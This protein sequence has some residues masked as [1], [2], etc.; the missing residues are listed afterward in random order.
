[1]SNNPNVLPIPPSELPNSSTDESVDDFV[2]E[3][4]N[5]CTDDFVDEVIHHTGCKLAN[6]IFLE[7]F[8]KKYSNNNITS[9]VASVGAPTQI[10]G[11]TLTESEAKY[12]D[13]Y[14]AYLKFLNINNTKYITD[15]NELISDGNYNYIEKNKIKMKKPE[16]HKKDYIDSIKLTIETLNNKLKNSNPINIMNDTINTS[17]LANK[18]HNYKKSK[19]T[20]D[21]NLMKE[22]INETLIAEKNKQQLYVTIFANTKDIATRS[23]ETITNLDNLL[24]I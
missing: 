14:F 22:I 18:L 12:F 19:Q 2:N 4:T 8:V 11:P 5:D 15:L 16:A 7:K 10:P 20:I 13:D 21:W 9:S 17:L 24:K 23:R 3:S 6:L 1:M